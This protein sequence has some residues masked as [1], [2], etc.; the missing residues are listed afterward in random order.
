MTKIIRCVAWLWKGSPGQMIHRSYWNSKLW[1][2]K[3][4]AGQ[5]ATIFKPLPIHCESVF[6]ELSVL[7]S[8]DFLNA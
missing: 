1:R 4:A 5:Q 7:Q 2:R 3:S 8:S 6:S